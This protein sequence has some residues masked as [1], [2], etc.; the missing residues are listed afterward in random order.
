LEYVPVFDDLAIRIKSKDINAGPRPIT[1][2]LLKAMPYDVVAVRQDAFELHAPAG[3]SRAIRVKYSMKGRGTVADCRVVLDVRVARVPLDS[4]R[5]LAL[6][7][8][9]VVEGLDS[10]F[11]PFE[12]V[13]HSSN[14]TEGASGRLTR[15]FSCGRTIT[16]TAWPLP[17]IARHLR[18]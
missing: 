16:I 4:G 14:L 17:K 13:I 12:S 15:E 10:A 6:I 5:G 11:V 9:Q 2:P 18:R 8:H 1:R 3:Y 7:E